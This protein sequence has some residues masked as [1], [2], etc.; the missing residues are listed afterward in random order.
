M[1]PGSDTRLPEIARSESAPRAM[2]T[3]PKRA[4]KPV[5]ATAGSTSHA[6][7]QLSGTLERGRPEQVVETEVAADEPLSRGRDREREGGQGDGLPGE[8]GAAGHHGQEE[9][10][11]QRGGEERGVGADRR[12]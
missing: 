12:E 7:S 3:R 6:S 2:P 5:T 9:R 8:P 10:H 11:T 1:A 4:R